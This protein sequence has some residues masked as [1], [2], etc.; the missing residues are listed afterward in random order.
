MARRR[1]GN[2]IEEEKPIYTEKI[3]LSLVPRKWMRGKKWNI[4]ENL[5]RF[6]GVF[7]I[8][9]AILSA[10]YGLEIVYPVIFLIGALLIFYITEVISPDAQ[11]VIRPIRVYKN[12]VLVYTTS[13]EKALG[14]KSFMTS[15]DLRGIKVKRM[16]LQTENGI[17]NLPTHLTF[18]LKNNMKIKMGRR[19]CT[20]LM[21]IIDLL[22]GLGIKE[23]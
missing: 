1:R 17:Q 2:T 21:S 14:K 20:E 11:R 7:L 10:I 19:N 9:M 16:N 5:G 18:V 15:D 13:F 4:L 3:P 8:F 23:L 22:D 6:V 12:G